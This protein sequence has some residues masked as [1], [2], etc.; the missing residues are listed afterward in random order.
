MFKIT[1]LSLALLL[2]QISFGYGQDEPQVCKSESDA[3]QSV[4]TKYKQRLDEIDQKG[5]DLSDDAGKKPAFKV[6]FDVKMKEQ[7]WIFDLPTVTVKD[8]DLIFGLPQVT[9]KTRDLSFDVPIFWIGRQKVGQHPEVKCD[10]G[11]IPKCTVK[12]YDNYIDVPQ[13]RM[14]TKHI[15]MDIPEFKF[16][17]TKIV[18]GIPEF[19]MVKQD[20]FVKIPE[21]TLKNIT[22]GGLPVYQDY[23]KR[24]K[25]LERDAGA[26][27]EDMKRDVS[28]ETNVL[29]SCLRT[30]L[31]AKR[32]AALQGIQ[33]G[34]DKAKAAAER[35]RA[36]GIDPSALLI[37]VDGVK[38][39]LATV[40]TDLEAKKAEI[41]KTFDDA[42]GKLDEQE[43]NTTNNFVAQQ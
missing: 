25:E 34:I 16:D 35:L 28:S 41:Q 42:A 18:L 43:K 23:D 11:F 32:E 14:E 10:K 27:Q 40:I 5:K 4:S 3:I 31:S 24:G 6:E 39:P 36:N 7:H 8:Q 1:S 9:M 21:F 33:D 26:L 29:F 38:K 19:T 30:D 37:E 20:W 22:I 13:T 2:N 12:W 15:K 17:N